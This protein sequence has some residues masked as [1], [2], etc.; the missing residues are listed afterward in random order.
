MTDTMPG[1]GD[2]ATWPPYTGQ[3]NDPRNPGDPLEDHEDT[4]P[5]N[6]ICPI[7]RGLGA[8]GE[9]HITPL[10]AATYIISPYESDAMHVALRRTTDPQDLIHIHM[11]QWKREVEANFPECICGPHDGQHPDAHCAC[12]NP[13]LKADGTLMARCRGCLLDDW[14]DW[15]DP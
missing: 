10:R 7:C 2:P 11:P 14:T 9:G 5:T 15:M 6:T 13:A 3:A 8:I 4:D 1:P 12:G